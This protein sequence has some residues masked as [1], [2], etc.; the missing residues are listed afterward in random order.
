MRTDYV[1]LPLSY[2]KCVPLVNSC[3]QCGLCARAIAKADKGRPLEDLSNAYV[4]IKGNCR[5][6]LSAA[7]FRDPPKDGPKPAHESVKGLA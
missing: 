1:H 6:F 2:A 3:P 4:W 7:H 5:S